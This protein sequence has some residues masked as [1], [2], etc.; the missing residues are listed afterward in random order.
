M[1][2]KAMKVSPEFTL[3]VVFCVSVL[4]TSAG[5]Q[6]HFVFVFALYE[7]TLGA[8]GLLVAGGDPFCG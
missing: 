5:V 2:K 6:C 3:A 7:G 1:L 4:Q 8:W